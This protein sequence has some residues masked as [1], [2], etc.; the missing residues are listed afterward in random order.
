[1]E[2]FHCTS[3]LGHS[4]ICI[5]GGQQ[6]D[7][8]AI[9]PNPVYGVSLEQTSPQQYRG[10]TEGMGPHSCH[11]YDYVGGGRQQDTIEIK[12]NPVYG[13]SLQLTPPQSPGETEYYINEGM[14]PD[15]C[16]LN[17]DYVK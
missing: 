3:D 6:E 12:P 15:S 14:G 8:I 1:M 5:G 16:E 10:E 4:I 9:K 13:V 7:T 17:Y 2:G 11:D